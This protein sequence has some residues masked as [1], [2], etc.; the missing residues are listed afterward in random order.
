MSKPLKML[1]FVLA[2][3]VALG[4]GVWLLLTAP[5]ETAAP[6]DNT[7]YLESR[8]PDRSSPSRWIT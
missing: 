2:A 5:Q 1:V 6:E 7:L 4:A 8:T 3:T